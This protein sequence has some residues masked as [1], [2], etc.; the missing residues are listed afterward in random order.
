MPLTWHWL[1]L[2]S[3]CR[4]PNGEQ[5]LKFDDERVERAD[6]HKAIEDNFGGGDEERTMTGGACGS[7]L[8]LLLLQYRSLRCSTCCL[9]L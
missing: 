8:L 6:A 2:L 5:W 3:G 9:S 4:R 7:L 1:L